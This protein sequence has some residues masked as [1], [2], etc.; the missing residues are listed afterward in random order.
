MFLSF[1][2]FLFKTL[3]FRNY[4]PSLHPFPVQREYQRAL[5]TVKLEKIF[6]KPFLFGL[7]G[8]VDAV[9][10][11]LKHPA[12]LS[13]I[14]SGSF[15][16]QIKIWDLMNRRCLRTI[17][18]YTG[19]VSG[20]CIPKNGSFFYSVGDNSIIKQWRLKPS[21]QLSTGQLADD[22]TSDDE[23]DEDGNQSSTIHTPLNSIISKSSIIG[24][25]HHYKKTLFVT[26]GS[27]IDLW[28]ET[29]TAPLKSY[30]P[31][32]DTSY[33]IKFNQVQT[34]VFACVANDRSIILFDCRRNDYLRKVVLQMRSNSISWN[35]MEAY[36]FTVANED[37][38]LYT[39]DMRKLNVPYRAHVDHVSAVL[40]LDYSPTGKE[41]AT[42]SY[43]KTLRIFSFKSNRSREIYH[44]KRMQR[45]TS[46][47]WSM[48]NEYIICGSNE[49]DIRVWKAKASKKLGHVSITLV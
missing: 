10:C 33:K 6:A 24:I 26:C 34:D 2:F 44:T 48:D 18:A 47:L 12:S 27:S 9:E 32:I 20:L 29:R 49:A 43:D 36:H 40:D 46:I 31:S 11:L 14:V 3:V 30:N 39:F 41:F 15:D 7:T 23:N 5:N 38:N 45:L 16:G 17:D 4:D 8:H 28:D 21:E 42:A 37:H 1:F 25:D 19:A 35:P 22:D 13:T